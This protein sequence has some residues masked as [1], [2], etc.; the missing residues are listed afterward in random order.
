MKYWLILTT[1]ILTCHVSNAQMY[2]IGLFAGGSNFVGDVGSTTYVNPNAFA[3]GGI[4]KWNRSARHAWRF[5]AI[6]TNLKALD[7]DSADPRRVQRDLWFKT[8]LIDVSA[9]MEFNFFNFDQ[10]KGD[11]AITP[12]LFTGISVFN[13]KNFHYDTS[14]DFVEQGDESWQIGIPLTFGV[15]AKVMG[16]FV[17]AAEV[18][19]KFTF[20]DNLDGSFPTVSEEDF[21]NQLKFGNLNNKDWYVFSGITISYTFGEKP[22][23]CFD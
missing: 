5:S 16:V 13:H 9:G 1:F 12:Y 18:S 4:V 2:E 3:F 22:C 14:L 20:T 17:V 8:D 7:A 21:P 6:F 23:Y 15:K 11:P 10:H 19:A